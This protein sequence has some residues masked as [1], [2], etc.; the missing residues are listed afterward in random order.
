MLQFLSLLP[1]LSLLPYAVI[2]CL[3]VYFG[4]GYFFF[5][6]RWNRAQTLLYGSGLGT[7]VGVICAL[8]SFAG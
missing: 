2:V 6:V 1:D 7:I 4:V 3:A 8:G 5:G